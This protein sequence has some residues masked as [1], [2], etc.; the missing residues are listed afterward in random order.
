MTRPAKNLL[1]IM[2]DEHSP[3][4]LGCHG[5]EIVQTPNLDALAAQGTRFSSA[6]CTSP[7]CIP[8]RAS[9]A[10]GKYIHQI[11]YWDNADAYDGATPSWHHKL[12]DRGHE[13]VSIGKLHFRLPGEDHGFTE[14]QI[15][16]HVIEGKGDLMGLVRSDLPVR[17][18]AY[19]MARFAGPGESQYTF[20][21]RE[22]AARAQVWLRDKARR[23]AGRP[24][25]LFV[26]FV[27]PHFPLTA[28]PEHF[29]RYY[30]R[31]LPMPKLYGKSERPRHPYLVDYAKS[32]NY[33][34]Y[35]DAGTVKK[36]VAGYYGLCSFLDENVGK[37]LR[38]LQDAG[39]ADDTRVL[40]TSDHGDNLGA[41]GLWGKT[42]LFEEAAGVPLIMAGADIARAKV[43]D[44]PVS[45]VDFYPFVLDAT[46][47]A[48][49]GLREGFPGVSLFDIADGAK[50]DRSVLVEY[51]GM[52]S[53]S[54]AF[55]I[56]HGKW[57]F[58]HY[59]RYPGQLF[60]LEA[61][62]EELRDLAADPRYAAVVEECRRRLQAICDP[63]E[64]D[65]RARSRQAELL[66]ANGG[67]EAVIARGDL[68]FTPA[69]G[70]VIAFD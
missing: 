58:I 24:W 51:H 48:E 43:V 29:Y 59:S 49:P 57:K 63:D 62:P 20:Y 13:V 42:T 53:T 61:D 56:R 2:S 7:V 16:M 35:F 40:Y 32:F 5:H 34:D 17:K 27:C 52:G 8:A 70:A 9:F 23:D 64:V 4:M 39:L 44:T 19:K 1:V 69:P 66:E 11:G 67:R 36:A 45:H 31:A 65:A 28:P 33:D 60:D 10:V 14:E 21:D 50:P 15:P 30:D 41:R 47:H 26:S 37:V 22:I 46:G 6:Y 55:M 25:V 54:G 18:G 12:R 68:G 38:A 3:K